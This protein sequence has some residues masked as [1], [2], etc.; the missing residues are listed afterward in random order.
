MST[1]GY[2][3]QEHLAQ[4]TFQ[5]RGLANLGLAK[6][7]YTSWPASKEFASHARSALIVRTLLPFPGI[8]YSPPAAWVACRPRHHCLI[9][10]IN[11]EVVVGGGAQA[12]P[13]HRDR[14]LHGPG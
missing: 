9:V 11:A 5:S 7:A 8:T 14:L 6:P 1:W 3:R 4:H 10:S 2:F 12:T 13:I